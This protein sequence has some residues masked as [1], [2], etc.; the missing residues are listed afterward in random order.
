[1]KAYRNRIPGDFFETKGSGESDVT[2]H[3][4]SYHLAL[5]DAGIEMCNIM[6]YSSIL[7]ATSKRVAKPERTFFTHG[8]VLESIVASHTVG[9]GERA[10]A[11]IIYAWLTDEQGE[12]KGGLVCEYGG[13]MP[14]EDV[15][16]HLQDMW[17]ELYTNGYDHLQRGEPNYVVESFVPTK[18]YGTALAALCFLGHTFPEDQR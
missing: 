12:V 13:S 18:S 7:P 2:I 11:A 10:T 5:C 1:M 17:E 6:T 4:G 14:E 8:E 15:R 3:A 9:P 16:P